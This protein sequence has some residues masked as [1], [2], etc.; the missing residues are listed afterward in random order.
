MESE[1]I[2]GCERYE[3]VRKDDFIITTP[4]ELFDNVDKRKL[5]FLE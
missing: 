5:Q 1:L 2:H 4:H 3:Q